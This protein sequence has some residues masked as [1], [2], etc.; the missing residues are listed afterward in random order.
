MVG[1]GDVYVV[2]LDIVVE[3]VECGRGACMVLNYFYEC[4]GG[5]RGGILNTGICHDVLG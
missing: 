2:R 5:S 4:E 1:V 3:L